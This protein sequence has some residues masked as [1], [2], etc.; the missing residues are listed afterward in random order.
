MYNKSGAGNIQ[1]EVYTLDLTNVCLSVLLTV[2]L[3][4]ACRTTQLSFT[5][6]YLNIC[7]HL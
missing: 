2:G 5:L 6:R 4:E 3:K 7:Q 1:L